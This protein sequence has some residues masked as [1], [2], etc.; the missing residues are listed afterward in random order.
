MHQCTGGLPQNQVGRLVVDT[1][2][3]IANSSESIQARQRSRRVIDPLSYRSTHC[4]IAC[5]PIA[6]DTS[7][8]ITTCCSSLANPRSPSTAE[9]QLRGATIHFEHTQSFFV[10]QACHQVCQ[11]SSRCLFGSHWRDLLHTFGCEE[12]LLTLW[13]IWRRVDR[14]DYVLQLAQALFLAVCEE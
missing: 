10:R 5:S 8:S 6:S 13:H 2:K 12:K 7:F 3:S 14:S 1:A 9:F 11:V 4:R